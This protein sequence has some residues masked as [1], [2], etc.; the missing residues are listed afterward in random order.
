MDEN[1]IPPVY[2]LSNLRNAWD[3]NYINFKNVVLPALVE[4]LNGVLFDEG[5]Y[6]GMLIGRSITEWE[7]VSAFQHEGEKDYSRDE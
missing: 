3:E 1:A 5:L 6:E 2:A 4:A 7:V